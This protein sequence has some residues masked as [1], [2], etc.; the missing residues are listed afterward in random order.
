[1]RTIVSLKT[2]LAVAD[3]Q[4]RHYVVWFDRE[5]IVVPDD[6]WPLTL[7]LL[8]TRLGLYTLARC[9]WGVRGGA[10]QPALLI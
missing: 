5:C 4:R 7:V 1:M 3:L 2:L 8:C 9:R 6:T 10:A